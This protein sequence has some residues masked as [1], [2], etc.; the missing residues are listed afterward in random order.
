MMTNSALACRS[1]AES[2]P[3]PEVG[4]EKSTAGEPTVTDMRS[5]GKRHGR[6]WRGR[7]WRVAVRVTRGRRDGKGARGEAGVRMKAM[8][9]WVMMTLRKRGVAGAGASVSRSNV[10]F[11]KVH[12]FIS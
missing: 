2:V 3:P 4:S 9:R 10:G 6:G 12:R 1:A 11:F 8:V 5:D 7:R